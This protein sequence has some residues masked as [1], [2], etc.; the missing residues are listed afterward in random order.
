MIINYPL[1][2]K[3]FFATLIVVNSPSFP[4]S[5]FLGS[6]LRHLYPFYSRAYSRRGR[7][8]VLIRI[9]NLI[10]SLIS[11]HILWFISFILRVEHL[12]Q[13]HLMHEAIFFH[14]IFV[15]FSRFLLCGLKFYIGFTL[16]LHSIIR[17]FNRHQI[18][19]LFY[20]RER[21]KFIS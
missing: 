5:A 21:L 17:S 3:H 8:L 20:I 18:S 1:C 4:F 15:S 11:C 7:L 13:R 2:C 6:Y 14:V 16:T 10:W 12:C 19:C 9:L